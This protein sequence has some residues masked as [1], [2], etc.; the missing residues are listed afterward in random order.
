MAILFVR[1]TVSRLDDERPGLRLLP[2]ALELVQSFLFPRARRIGVSPPVR[3]RS[4][5]TQNE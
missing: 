5:S 3:Y 1:P 2:D 4:G